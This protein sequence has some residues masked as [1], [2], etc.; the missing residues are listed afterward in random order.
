LTTLTWIIAAS[1]FGGALSVLA[2]ASFALSARATMVPMLISYAIGALLGAAFLEVLP[3]AIVASAD[4]RGAATVVLAGILGFFV[5]EKLVPGAIAMSSR[6]R[7]TNRRRS[8]TT[9]D[10][11]A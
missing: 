4:A 7:A 3:H 2:A 6:A 1:V 9:M 5:L 10:A 11:A 8:R